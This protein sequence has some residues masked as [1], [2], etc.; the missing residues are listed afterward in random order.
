MP[1]ATRPF[2]SAS[3]VAAAAAP[4]RPTNALNADRNVKLVA[5]GDAFQDRLT[6]QPELQL[7]RDNAIASKIDVPAEKQFIGFDAYQQVIDSGVD[8]VLLCTPPHFRPAHF[9]A[10][11]RARKHV[12]RGKAGGRRR[13]RRPQSV[14]G[15]RR[16]AAAAA[17]RG[18]RPVLSLSTPASASSFRR[19]HD[20]A[21]GDIVA[22]QVNYNTGTPLASPA[23]GEGWSDM[24]WQMRN[25]LYFTWL[26]GDFNVEQHVH[27]LD[28]MAWA[29]QGRIP[30]KLRRSGWPPGA[31]RPRVRPHLRSHGLRL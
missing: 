25:W 10:A 18:L 29:M 17:E 21:I 22:M 28:K 23:R 27:S 8:A 20:G 9:E 13:P 26:S 2:V 14:G 19:I 5:M 16:S 30:D 15:Q 11:V 31:H 1:T 7:R 12:F 24:E 6:L 4:G 3:S